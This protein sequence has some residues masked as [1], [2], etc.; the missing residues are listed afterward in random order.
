[1]TSGN[2]KAQVTPC[3]P[4]FY[5]PRESSD[6]EKTERACREDPLTDTSGVREGR[7]L[8]AGTLL[9]EWLD[10][11][12]QRPP[13]RII[14]QISKRIK[15]LLGE[16]V[17]YEYVRRGLQLWQEKGD[18]HPA[19]LDSFVNTAMNGRGNSRRQFGAAQVAAAMLEDGPT[20]ASGWTAGQ[21][22]ELTDG[23]DP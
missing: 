1:M 5:P 3:E 19:T 12:P 16:G 15:Q 11:C 23:G 14:G 8:N 18:T 13:A 4:L 20:P 22:L 10:H 2:V 17:A 6:I 9:A 7:P 21:L